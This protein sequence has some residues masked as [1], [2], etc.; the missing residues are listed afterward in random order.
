MHGPCQVGN[1]V[2]VG[3]NSVIFDC[4]LGNDIKVGHCALVESC[5]VPSHGQIP[6]MSMV[7]NNPDFDG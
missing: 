3:F 1:D 4:E 6:S 7:N 2:F 5:H